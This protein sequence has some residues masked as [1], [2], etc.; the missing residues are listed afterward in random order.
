MYIHFFLKLK[1]NFFL[2]VANI[3]TNVIEQ[4]IPHSE[5]GRAIKQRISAKKKMLPVI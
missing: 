3:R 5:A 4:F 2:F 1:Q